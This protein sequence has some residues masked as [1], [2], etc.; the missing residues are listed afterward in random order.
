MQER[1]I[2]R[3]PAVIAVLM[4]PNRY[5]LLLPFRLAPHT[6]AQAARARNVKPNQMAY[7]V[8]KF[9]EAGL[10]GPVEV[11]GERGQSYR[12][13][14]EEFILMPGN[15][16]ATDEIVE[17]QYGPLWTQL[18]RAVSA[19]TDEVATRW[20]IRVFL[21]QGRLLTRQEVPT[22]MIGQPDLVPEGNALNLWLRMRFDRA[23]LAELR[24]DLE[25]LY[26]RYSKRASSDPD[27]PRHLLH[28][29]L[30]REPGS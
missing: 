26:S 15:G 24:A 20:A 21:Y 19:D 22:E 2:V 23:T 10:I 28:L 7:W 6:T 12:T 17:K 14:A 5:T 9:L 8:E 16:F 1:L 18:Q 13:A 27:L 29:A 30:V 3:D 11:P 4:D 25:D